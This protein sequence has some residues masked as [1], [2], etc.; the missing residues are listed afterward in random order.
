MDIQSPLLPVLV[1]G[2]AVLALRVGWRKYELKHR[3]MTP[4]AGLLLLTTMN[5]WAH[6]VGI[7]FAVIYTLLTLTLI[8]WLATAY[9]LE[10]RA[11]K[12]T[13]PRLSERPS[14]TSQPHKLATFV[15]AGPLTLVT[16][17][18]VTIALASLLPIARNEQLVVGAFVYPLLIATVIYW[19]CSS[20]RLARN[21]LLLLSSCGAASAYLFL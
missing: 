15:V 13:P 12:E 17:C 11:V 16:G 18:L 10:C 1:C 6:R 9:G 8:A 21:S 14:N 7:E 19:L 4:L 3:V 20:E 5:I 2:C